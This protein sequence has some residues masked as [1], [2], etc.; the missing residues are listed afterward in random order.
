MQ[1]FFACVLHTAAP[2]THPESWPPELKPHPMK[3]IELGLCNIKFQYLRLLINPELQH[4]SSAILGILQTGNLS[5]RNLWNLLF[6]GTE[7]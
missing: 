6:A 2:N 1:H 3:T 4:H 7:R 5:L